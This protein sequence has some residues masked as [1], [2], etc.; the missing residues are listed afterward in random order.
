MGKSRLSEPSVLVGVPSI[1]EVLRACDAGERKRRLDR[2]YYHRV[3][4]TSAYLE[5]RRAY[6]SRPEVKARQKAYLKKYRSRVS[7]G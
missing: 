5:M 1:E 2:L 6:F 7:K 3:S 4:G